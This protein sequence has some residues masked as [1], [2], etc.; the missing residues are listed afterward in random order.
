M[1]SFV[2]EG[3]FPLPPGSSEV[4]APA[5]CVAR[6]EHRRSVDETAVFGFVISA[7]G[8]CAQVVG[9]APAARR[10]PLWR[11]LAVARRSFG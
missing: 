4:L 9:R 5:G 3:Y 8:M 6:S 10:N 1:A 2:G 11:H 7:M